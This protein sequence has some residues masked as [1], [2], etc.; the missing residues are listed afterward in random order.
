MPTRQQF[1]ALGTY[2]VTNVGGESEVFTLRR[3]TCDFVG[4]GYDPGSL[5]LY[6]SSSN[7]GPFT[8][9]E[10][11]DLAGT[12]TVRLHLDTRKY[13]RVSFASQPLGA[14]LY[15]DYNNP[16]LEDAA[17]ISEGADDEDQTGTGLTDEQLALLESAVQPEELHPVATSGDYDTLDNTPAIPPTSQNPPLEFPVTAVLTE[18]INHNLGYRPQVTVLDATGRVV[19]ACSEHTSLFQTVVTFSAPLT[20]VVQI[21]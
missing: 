18:T 5:I 17:N 2:N 15:I 21:L 20:G 3:E 14:R 7:N 16:V 6:S 11:V 9:V 10:N 13:Y 8:G 1:T 19:N 12:G 4:S